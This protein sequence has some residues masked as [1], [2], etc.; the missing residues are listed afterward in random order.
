MPRIA[1]STYVAQLFAVSATCGVLATL[2]LATQDSG[3]LAAAEIPVP[4]I[5]SAIEPMRV[6]EL[7]VV[8]QP[9]PPPAPSTQLLFVFRAGGETYAKLSDDEPKHGKRKMITDEDGTSTVAEVDPANLPA[10]FRAW[11]DKTFTVDG[12]CLATVKGFAVVTRMEGDPGYAGLE[13][14]KWTVGT[15]A[16]AGTSQLAARLDV[17]K[18]C[19]KPLYARDASVAP[20]AALETLDRPDLV[21]QARSALLATSAADDAQAAW[22]EHETGPWIEHAEVTSFTRRHPSTGAIYVG[23]HASIQQGC[24]GPEVNVW[25]LFKVGRDGR[26]VTLDVRKLDSIYAVERILDVDNDGK[27]ELLGRD[28]LGLSLVLTRADGEEISRLPMQFHGCPC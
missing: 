17:P 2:A 23:M 6:A 11:G 13:D 7:E 26:L 27:L 28:W 5:E 20:M 21:A 24:G 8:R 19:T 25:G 9:P 3:A 12:G 10:K 4:A 14:D 15:A 1:S 22:A 18:A 16:A